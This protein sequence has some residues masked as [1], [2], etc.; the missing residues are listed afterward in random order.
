MIQRL[1]NVRVKDQLIDPTL[2]QG[3]DSEAARDQRNGKLRTA[4]TGVHPKTETA[5]LG[6]NFTK[7]KESLDEQAQ[8]GVHS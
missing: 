4:Q 2:N 1:G 5:K 8:A 6:T 3:F 7:W